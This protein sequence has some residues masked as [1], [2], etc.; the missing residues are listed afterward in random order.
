MIRL[1]DQL[2]NP[3]GIRVVRPTAQATK[4][5]PRP[6]PC[7]FQHSKKL[8]QPRPEEAAGQ[9]TARAVQR[10]AQAPVNGAQLHPPLAQQRT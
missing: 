9:N 10:P 2:H 7:R 4:K 8:V 3:S 6:D 5:L 1:S